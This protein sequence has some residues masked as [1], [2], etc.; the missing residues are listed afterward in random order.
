MPKTKPLSLSV[1]CPGIEI[2]QTGVV[3]AGPTCPEDIFQAVKDLQQI[4]GAC[5]WVIADLIN[6]NE[7]EYGQKYDDCEEEYGISK[8]A[9]RTMCW[10]ARSW[11][12]ER[13]REDLSFAHHRAVT[14]LG[15]ATADELLECAAINGW[16][17]KQLEAEARDYRE[18]ENIL[19]QALPEHPSIEHEAPD[20]G[21]EM[22]P[23]GDN[24]E[25]DHLSPR[26]D[27]SKR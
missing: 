5:S 22:S 16:S 9:A 20:E 23:R 3:K 25:E 21:G 7:T 2:S 24:L 15:S 4:R 18:E 17:V 8:D 12:L 14:S 11:D 26:G 10:V 13:R 6:L 27:I 19:E 1:T